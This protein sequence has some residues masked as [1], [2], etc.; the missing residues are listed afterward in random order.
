[1]TKSDVRNRIIITHPPLNFLLKYRFRDAFPIRSKMGE[2]RS[3][4]EGDDRLAMTGSDGRSRR[5]V[6]RS[7]ENLLYED[8]FR[9]TSPIKFRTGERGHALEGDDRLS[10]TGSDG[11]SRTIVARPSENLV[12]EDSLRVTS[13]IKFRT[14][15]RGHAL[16]GADRLSATELGGRSRTIVIRAPAVIHRQI[17][18]GFG[19]GS[20][21]AA[22]L[23]TIDPAPLVVHGGPPS[24]SK[25]P[26]N[27]G[28]GPKAL[29]QQIYGS[30][31]GIYPSLDFAKDLKIISAGIKTASDLTKARRRYPELEHLEP[32]QAKIIKERDV[33]KS[34]SDSGRESIAIDL[35]R[36]SD[37]VYSMIERR[38]RIERERR[39]LYG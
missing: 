6:T 32:V 14:G 13:P 11:R 3:A 21:M 20:E 16:E 25:S 1:M 4:W 29:P 26:S 12:S 18:R 22:H 9:V 7:S 23:S 38:V 31:F 33:L 35:N 36:I 37:Q 30:G 34:E 28:E 8:R 17:S 19:E 10:A 2:E 24:M 5:I 15:E 27:K 39:G